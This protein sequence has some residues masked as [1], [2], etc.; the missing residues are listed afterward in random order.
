MD[1]GSLFAGSF[2]KKVASLAPLKHRS[3]SFWDE[4]ELE[5]LR[6]E[7]LAAAAALLEYGRQTATS[8]GNSQVAKMGSTSK[9][10]IKARLVHD[11]RPASQGSSSSMD[12][13]HFLITEPFNYLSISPELGEL[14]EDRRSLFL[15][16]ISKVPLSA[17]RRKTFGSF[18]SKEAGGGGGEEAELSVEA[19]NAESAA[20]ASSSKLEPLAMSNGDSGRIQRKYDQITCAEDT[21]VLRVGQ[22]IPLA[23]SQMYGNI[24]L[25]FQQGE[26]KA[27]NYSYVCV[28]GVQFTRKHEGMYSPGAAPP[29][30]FGNAD[31]ISALRPE[32]S[33]R[34]AVL[35]LIHFDYSSYDL[36]AVNFG[37]IKR[38][39]MKPSV[40]ER[41]APPRVTV[42]E[43][44]EEEEEQR[45]LVPCSSISSNVLHEYPQARSVGLQLTYLNAG[46]DKGALYR[47]KHLLPPE[48]KTMMDSVWLLP[49]VSSSRHG[50]RLKQVLEHRGDHLLCFAEP[51]AAI[52]D[53]ASD[54][55]GS[56]TAFSYIDSSTKPPTEKLW[57]AY[58][59]GSIVK[60]GEQLQLIQWALK[61]YGTTACKVLGVYD[62]SN[63]KAL[64]PVHLPCQPY[65]A[66]IVQMDVA[67]MSTMPA[68]IDPPKPSMDVMGY[69]RD[70][71][72]DLP[73][74]LTEFCL[75]VSRTNARII[76]QQYIRGN[77]KGQ[78]TDS[79]NYRDVNQRGPAT[80][81]YWNKDENS[82][83]A[84]NLYESC[85]DV[86]ESFA[87]RHHFYFMTNIPPL[88]ASQQQALYAE[89]DPES[90]SLL[91]ITKDKQIAAAERCAR[92][93]GIQLPP[94]KVV[95]VLFAVKNEISVQFDPRYKGKRHL[96]KNHEESKRRRT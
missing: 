25:R 81:N 26:M 2:E 76:T 10:N 51:V 35:S 34:E 49:M 55:K 3:F 53:Q 87:A 89:E 36:A 61:A 1:V 62:S 46:D 54:A 84:V 27:P 33:V 21:V 69:V 72:N 12:R 29:S 17:Q 71:V 24:G 91:L 57:L 38:M 7:Q 43:V 80:Q 40:T 70:V 13:A 6:E 86:T 67:R 22:S 18:G 92:K 30:C 85:E 65:A 93:L 60:R 68:N 96:E 75:P 5:E 88:S 63:W 31:S 41:E 11:I 42:T 14:S 52:F 15:R 66:C 4:S 45:A 39:L 44:T 74:Y 79:Y 90:V 32:E 37:N 19:L 82:I 77:T 73:R 58:N 16:V 50:L 8:A 64:A 23:I 59:Q 78:I 95:G 83:G 94:T 20:G 48:V 9:V 47:V 56:T 28:N